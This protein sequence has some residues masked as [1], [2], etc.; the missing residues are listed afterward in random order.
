MPKRRTSPW[1]KIYKHHKSS[2]DKSSSDFDDAMKSM[3]ELD[4]RV[5]AHKA[6]SEKWMRDR[7]EEK[8]DKQQDMNRMR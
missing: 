2:F 6:E 4:A 1:D 7:A 3:R 5:A 8:K